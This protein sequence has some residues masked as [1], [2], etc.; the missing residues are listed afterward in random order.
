LRA[1]ATVRPR[2]KP[3]L[4]P[5]LASSRLPLARLAPAAA[6]ALFAGWA[7]AALPFYPPGWWAALAA[8]AAL[9]SLVG[10]RAGLALALLVPVFPLGNHGLG[11]ALA[12]LAAAA[13]WLALSWREP[14]AG[15]FLTAG[16]LLS[17]VLALGFLPLAAQLVR[18]PLRR[19]LGVA[20]ACLAAAAAE[21]AGR[22]G[23]LGVAGEDAPLAAAGAVWRLLLE[24]PSAALLGLGLA[25]S[26]VLLPYARN[27]GPWRVAGFGAAMLGLT[28]LPAPGLPAV[29]LVAAAWATCALLALEPYARS[30]R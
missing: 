8:A 9:L 29:P 2:A 25:A 10:A 6:A 5:A 27:A 19:F 1:A 18:S 15:L 26:S 7:A 23:A 30:R 3:R 16:P 22:L 28:L 20:A 14:R 13:L 11:L 12:Y 17:P 21:A 4:R 24:H